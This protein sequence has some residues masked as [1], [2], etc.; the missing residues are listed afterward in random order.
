MA[1]PAK[2]VQ[3]VEVAEAQA[4]RLEGG[5][6]RALEVRGAEQQAP[7][8]LERAGVQLRVTLGPCLDDA[9]NE[10]VGMRNFSL[11]LASR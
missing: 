9:V 5:D 8:D 6:D 1:A 3:D 10:S 7:D 11:A 4:K 2:R